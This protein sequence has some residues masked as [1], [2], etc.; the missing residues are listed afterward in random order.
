[1]KR[2]WLFVALLLAVNPARATGWPVIDIANDIHNIINYIQ[3]M[4]E[5]KERVEH[6]KRQM[7]NLSAKDIGFLLLRG[8]GR[9]ERLGRSVTSYLQY[10][11][12][13]SS[14]W[15]QSAETILATYYALPERRLGSYE[16]DI[17]F[18]FGEPGRR[19][20]EDIQS[21]Y[22]RRA[23]EMDVYHFLAAQEE[24]AQRRL[25]TLGDIEG[26]MG[27]LGDR[28]EVA[29]L[30]TIGTALALIGKQNEASLDA[31][32]MM[33][34]QQHMQGMQAADQKTRKVQG[35]ILRTMREQMARRPCR[36]SCVAD[37]W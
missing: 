11:D 25:M 1:M 32:H 2:A 28:S 5:Y 8:A 17:A 27:G 19:V 15:R 10:L 18:L 26:M 4:L 12:P 33:L 24:P 29:Q 9:D 35:E 22:E 21:A 23:P 20:Q 14:D 3:T 7:E 13:N 37:A 6:Y 16:I 34:S 31:M 30:Q 36:R